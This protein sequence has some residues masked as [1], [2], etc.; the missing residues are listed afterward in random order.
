MNRSDAVTRLHDAAALWSTDHATP[1]DVV[2]AACDVL[3]DGA[4]G[5]ALAM[6]AAVALR[7]AQNSDMFENLEQALA[8]VGLP[9]YEP[10]SMAGQEA[11]L[12]VMATRALSGD[13]D[14]RSFAAWAHHTFGHDRL[15][16]AE[17]LAELD[18]AYDTIDY[19]DLTVQ[20]IDT[21]VIAEAHRLAVATPR[22]T[23]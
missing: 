18:D 5:D 7:T 14:P 1:A 17:R 4:D 15:P 20:D 21:D 6:L 13:L 3:A 11:T 8:E 16:A 19:T 22:L 2:R 23:R 12:A 9:Y 10:D